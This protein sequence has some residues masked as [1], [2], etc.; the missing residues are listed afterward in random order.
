M[1]TVGLNTVAAATVLTPTSPDSAV[2]NV[3]D[4]RYVFIDALRGLAALAVLLFHIPFSPLHDALAATL[5]PTIFGWIADGYLGVYLF[6]VISGF[7]IAHSLRRVPLTAAGLGNFAARRQLRLD[8]PYWVTIWIM[9]CMSRLL[10]LVAPLHNPKPQLSL[11]VPN[12]FYLQRI[13]NV[14]SIL[15]VAWTLCIEVQFYMFVATLLLLTQRGLGLERLTRTSVAALFLTGLASLGFH[16]S[17]TLQVWMASYWCYFVLGALSYYVFRRQLSPLFLFSFIS[18]MVLADWRLYHL[19]LGLMVGAA[20][21]LA[22]HSVG[23][24][25][26]LTTLWGSAPIQ[27]FGRISYSLYL[28][29]WPVKELVMDLGHHLTRGSHVWALIWAVL[30][31]AGSIIVA[32]VLHI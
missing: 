17:D 13:F 31:V 20:T 24:L 27:Y 21:A 2:R 29:H 19:K 18:I 1:T 23:R 3:I 4:D 22:I 32:H 10:Y 9:V 8:P 30:A 11:V 7:V 5:H 26:R 16:P 25:G 28:V 15:P 6:F 12:L 14:G